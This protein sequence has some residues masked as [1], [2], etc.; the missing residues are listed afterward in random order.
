MI[1]GTCLCRPPFVGDACD[2]IT[3]SP[4]PKACSGKGR[5]GSDGVCICDQGFEGEADC[6]RASSDA[7]PHACSAHGVCAGRTCI[8]AAGF[9]GAGCERLV[10]SAGA[11][12]GVAAGAAASSVAG[13][14][15]V[16]PFGCSG[17]GVCSFDGNCHCQDGYGGHACERVVET[18]SCPYNCSGHGTCS[19]GRGG[20]VDGGASCRCEAQLQWRWGGAGCEQLALPEGC[21]YGCSGRGRC[22]VDPSHPSVGRCLC[23]DGF[24]DEGCERVR[25]CPY[26]CR[27]RGDC[28]DGRCVCGVGWKGPS[29]DDPKCEH[30]CSGHGECLAPIEP[31]ATGA[32]LCAGGWAGV[33]CEEWRP[34]CPG[35]CSGHGECRAGRCAC[36]AGFEGEACERRPYGAPKTSLALSLGEASCG[37]RLCSRH[38]SCMRGRA[39][40]TLLCACFDGYGGRDC[41]EVADRR[42]VEVER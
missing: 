13:A 38:G 18:P 6:S 16:C 42:R 17:R 28:V 10:I 1:N 11:A 23:Q 39:E 14:S 21:P 3:T 2:R 35:A 27:G 30:D 33:A 5:C 19:G 25:P 31:G 4:C 12:A 41:S 7:C 8:C 20:G 34:H 37:A 36:A 22:A 24:G 29:C 40:G 15:T 26:K 32:C 9:T